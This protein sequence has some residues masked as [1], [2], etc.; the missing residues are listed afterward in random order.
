MDSWKFITAVNGYRASKWL[1]GLNADHTWSLRC[2]D[3]ADGGK[4]SFFGIVDDET[5]TRWGL[6]TS[7]IITD[8]NFIYTDEFVPNCKT[9]YDD[10]ITLQWDSQ[11][12]NLVYF[13]NMDF[14]FEIHVGFIRRVVPI[15]YGSDYEL[16]DVFSSLRP[17]DDNDD[18]VDDDDDVHHH[19]DAAARA[20]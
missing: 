7:G 2:K 20:A 10:L 17:D 19:Y 18:D 16:C 11:S 5:N 4:Y 15:F 8:R 3:G 6:S 13:K 12:G 9:D 1:D 14:I